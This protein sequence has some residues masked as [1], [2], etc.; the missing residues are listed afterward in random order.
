MVIESNATRKQTSYC[1]LGTIV[2]K[3]ENDFTDLEKERGYELQWTT[4]DEAIQL[5]K[6]DIPD[7][8]TGKRV[9]QRDICILEKA[10]EMI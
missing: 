8:E 3:S 7:N 2:R 5:I 10:K 9:Q 1:Y 6:S 4:L